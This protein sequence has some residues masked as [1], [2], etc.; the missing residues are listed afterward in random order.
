[1][2]A[3]GLEFTSDA[4]GL[5]QATVNDAP[6]ISRRALARCVCESMG[7]R[8]AN[9]KLKEA[10]CRKA[11]RVL[12]EKGIV[13]L[14]LCSMKSPSEKPAKRKR[15]TSLENIEVVCGVNDLGSVEIEMVKSRYSKGAGIWKDLMDSAHY[16]GSGPLCG[17]QIRYLI[18]SSRYGY[19]G[20]L[21]FSSGTWALR[22]RDEYIGWSETA[23]RNNIQRIVCNSR[24]L[25]L[26]TV[27]VPNLASYILSRCVERIVRDWTERYG[28]EPVLL[29]T[30]VDPKRFFG[31]SYRAANWVRVGQTSGR[32][33]AEREEDGGA[34]D[35]YLYPLCPEW[36]KILHTVPQVGLGQ[37]PRPTDPQD[38][39]EE[40]LGTV[41]FYDE[42]LKRRLFSL[43][44]EFYGDP[45]APIPQACEGSAAKAKAV[46]RFFRND[47]VCMD[48]VLCAHTES[49][50][51]R[52]KPHKVVLA[53]QDTTSL[54]YTTHPAMEGIGPIGTKAKGSIGLLVHD[55][56]AFT[57]E[58]TPLGLLNVQYW[59]RDPDDIGKK[60]RRKKLA[61]EEKE[62]IKWL[63][64][65][66]AVSEVQKLCPETM[67]VSVGDRES[68]I[69]EFFLEAAKNPQGPRLLV[70]CER[71]RNRTVG[72]MNLWE[73]MLKEP[74]GAIRIV[75]VPKKGSRP[76]RD[77]KLE[78][79]YAR[80]KLKA[81]KGTGYPSV[82]VWTV[83]AREIDYD[84]TTVKSPLNWMLLT[85]V[86]VN[87][88]EDACERL[89][90]YTRRWGIEVYHRTLKSGCKIEERQL[91]LADGLEACLA[92]DM[93]VA[94][95][96]YHLTMLAREVPN[97]PCTVF[98]EEA[99]WKALYMF[100]NKNTK[101]LDKPPT[102][103]EAIRTLA[104]LGGFLGRKS[105]GEPGT[106]VL[107]RALQRL[108]DITATCLIFMPDLRAGP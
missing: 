61:I 22:W 51:E 13:E 50:I 82:E 11:L 20:G 27:H 83:Y 84:P 76:A 44:R 77:A 108:D 16:L 37:R 75:R 85:T 32:R 35:I 41:A 53:V 63:K 43:V 45:Q 1:M 71:T 33:G 10:N 81:P 38:W 103:R 59:A 25:I 19:I 54:N 64:S 21:S 72:E 100:V 107:W 31:T 17:A 36:R 94:W 70:R 88:I 5:I 14:P 4:I 26:P 18:S 89:D 30:F 52:I 101:P 92:I 40:E 56:M 80:V 34:K 29:E 2:R 3:C 106:V 48:R 102:L 79:R 105:D 98:F 9:G 42:R 6:S 58:G 65:Y 74:V 46:Y 60:H 8:A 12:N 49:T 47:K 57:P 99:E 67:L 69:Y 62:S 87:N 104:R 66:R 95:R 73:K 97:V 78:V 96:I 90:W 86:E 7:W 68:D 15:A 93:I 28:I 91:G 23:R 55:T 39:V 24:F